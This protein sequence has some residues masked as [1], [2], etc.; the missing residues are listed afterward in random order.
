MGPLLARPARQLLS[1]RFGHQGALVPLVSARF[2]ISHESLA[3]ASSSPRSSRRI[4]SVVA[5]YVFDDDTIKDRA[6]LIA[7][8]DEA[9]YISKFTGKNRTTA[10]RIDRSMRER[11]EQEK[12]QARGRQ[13][14][15]LHFPNDP[16]WVLRNVVARSQRSQTRTWNT[17]SGC[18]VSHATGRS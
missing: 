15:Q 4:G 2:F 13:R 6:A 3:A 7:A 14:S 16:V 9:A 10:W 5:D 8:A 11:I 12:A 17:P 1:P 18:R